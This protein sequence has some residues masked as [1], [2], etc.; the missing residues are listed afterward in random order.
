MGTNC[1]YEQQC[2][3]ET[4]KLAIVASP[5]VAGHSLDMGPGLIDKG[6]CVCEKP[7]GGIWCAHPDWNDMLNCHYFEYGHGGSPSGTT[8]CKYEQQC[9][10]ETPKLAIV[11][12]PEVAGHS[13]D[14]GPGLID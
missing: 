2:P 12:S 10:A 1:K 11:A 8:N 5:E 9:P 7:G 4:P 13:L 6:F 14:M 3:A